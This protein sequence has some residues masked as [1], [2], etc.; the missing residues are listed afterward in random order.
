MSPSAVATSLLP[1]RDC[2]LDELDAHLEKICDRAQ[3][4]GGERVERIF[5]YAAEQLIAHRNPMPLYSLL[6]C[7]R[8]PVTIEEFVE[9]SDYLGNVANVWPT[10]MPD[11]KALNPD[12][13]AGEKPVHEAFLGGAT[14]I[15]K[16]TVAR[17][18]CFTRCIS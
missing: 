2:R 15:G 1:D 6:Q 17:S 9:H 11:L 3:A 10:L 7:R 4:E 8:I 18:H 13:F 12:V 16:S 5:R 14:G